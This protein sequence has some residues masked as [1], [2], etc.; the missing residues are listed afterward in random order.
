MLGPIPSAISKIKKK[1]R[2]QIILK[3][4]NADRISAQLLDIKKR[5]NERYGE[6][7]IVIDKNPVHVY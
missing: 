1:Y 4:E 2:W 5:I 6:V 3:C 7:L